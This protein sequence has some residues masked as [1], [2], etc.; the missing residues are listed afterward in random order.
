MVLWSSLAEILEAC[1]GALT[2]LN[3][4][5][6]D[7]SR[8]W[9]DLFIKKDLEGIKQTGGGDITREFRSQSGVGLEVYVDGIPEVLLPKFLKKIGF[10]HLP[11]AVEQKRHMGGAFS[12][13]CQFQHQSSLHIYCYLMPIMNLYDR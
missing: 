2:G 13:F 9:A 7:Y 5:Q 12:P 10:P 1:Q 11:G 3:L 8:V 6:N 4:I